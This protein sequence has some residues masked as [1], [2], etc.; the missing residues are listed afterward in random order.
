LS[1]PT[2]TN[3]TPIVRLC[4]VQISH[5]ICSHSGSPFC[6]RQALPIARC[7]DLFGKSRWT[8]NKGIEKNCCV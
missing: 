1:I 5:F 8:R 7:F 3:D 4:L 6:F 2:T